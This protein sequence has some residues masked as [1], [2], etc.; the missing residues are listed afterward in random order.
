[1]FSDGLDEFER[2]LEQIIAGKHRRA[3]P[4]FAAAERTFATLPGFIAYAN[5]LPRDLRTLHRRQRTLSKFPL[6][7]EQS[8]AYR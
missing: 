3:D 7:L 6:E 8:A 2:Q 4:H 1:M 5:R